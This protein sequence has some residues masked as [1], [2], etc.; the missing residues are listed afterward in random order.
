MK[1]EM[2]TYLSP[3]KK[4]YLIRSP[5]SHDT[6]IILKCLKICADDSK[7]VFDFTL[8]PEDENALGKIL[9]FVSDSMKDIFVIAATGGK[10]AAI[11][12]ACVYTE[13]DEFLC[14]MLL[15]VRKSYRNQGVGKQL[16]NELI[17]FSGKFNIVRTETFLNSNQKE[18]IR[19]FEQNGFETVDKSNKRKMVTL[20][21]LP[22]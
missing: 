4:Y 22:E 1:C 3:A 17:K 7:T 16:L 14:K 10:I 15:F 2:R 19:F 11:G 13:N 18:A 9:D 20:V 8:L 6:D 5:D 21:S 12:C